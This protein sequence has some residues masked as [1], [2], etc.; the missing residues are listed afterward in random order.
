MALQT[1][2][3]S[4]I[5]E[6]QQ[7]ILRRIYTVAR[8]T[9]DLPFIERYKRRKVGQRAKHA[10]C[11]RSGRVISSYHVAVAC[12]LLIGKAV[13]GNWPLGSVVTIQA[14][15]SDSIQNRSVLFRL[16]VCLP[17]GHKRSP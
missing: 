15:I 16:G 12:F 7:M 11:C 8:V 13:F 3:A 17:V 1:N 5:V 9:A 2:G 4:F 10:V 6:Y 14:I